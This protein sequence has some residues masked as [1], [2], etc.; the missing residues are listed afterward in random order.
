MFNPVKL[1]ARSLIAT[2][3]VGGGV[4]QL[5]GA[6]HLGPVVDDAKEEYGIDVD[7]PGQDLVKLNGAGM[8]AAG[9]AMALGILPRISALSLLGLLIPTTIVSHPF[10]KME[11]RE[12]QENLTSTAS[13]AAVAGGLLMVAISPK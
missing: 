7:V 2:V 12:R 11:G 1:V 3:F 13:N 8:I 6:A 5:K 9:G 10:W 4:A